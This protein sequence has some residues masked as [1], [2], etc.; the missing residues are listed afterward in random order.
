MRVIISTV[1]VVTAAL[2]GCSAS[3][4][5]GSASQPPNRWVMLAAAQYGSAWPLTADR[6][7]VRCYR[8]GGAEEVTV[9]ING[10]EYAVNSAARTTGKWKDFTTSGYWKADPSG[11]DQKV[12]IGPLIEKGLEICP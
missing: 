2:S 7:I 10:T 11:L 4:S 9:T 3:S 1:A 8:S 12:D 5:A 6:A